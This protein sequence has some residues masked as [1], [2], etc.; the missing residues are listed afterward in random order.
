MANHL[1]PRQRKDFEIAVI[2]ALR[3]EVDAVEALFDVFWEE[4]ETYGKAVGDPNAYITGRLGDHNVVLVNLPGMGIASSSS[5]A[6]SLRSSFTGIKLGLVVGICGG[7]PF[8][9]DDEKEILLGDVIIS[10]GI[11]PFDTGRQFP[12][13]MVRKDTLQ[14]NLGRP[15]T[16]IRSCL[17]QMARRRGR[18]Q[19]KDRTA[20]YLKDLLE[21]EGFEGSKYPSTNEDIL[22][23]STYRH[24][25]QDKTACTICAKC[26]SKEDA[27]CVLALS[28]SCLELQCDQTKQV[29]RERLKKAKTV[30]ASGSAKEL[31]SAFTPAVHFGLIASG[32][33]V[34]KSGHHREDTAKK[35]KVI[36][37]EMEGSGAWDNFP[38][39]VIKGVCDYA[40]SP[41][42]KIWQQYAAATAAA[43]MKAFLNEWR[44]AD[45]PLQPRAEINEMGRMDTTSAHAISRKSPDV[46]QIKLKPDVVGNL[47]NA[48]VGKVV[49]TVV[50]LLCGQE[51][52]KNLLH[53]SDITG[54]RRVHPN[55]SGYS[56]V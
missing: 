20:E 32:G 14:E 25:H 36:A 10:T 47:Q 16:E 55:T 6:A 12:N 7:V 28:A 23:P 21:K 19:L 26:E 31:E 34:M 53:T 35:E 11:I 39:V 43:C 37:F 42:N 5:V 30:A 40:D 46:F 1:R 24:K 15:N 33:Q 44:V 56:H 22:Y 49:N 27:V 8:G 9:I 45:V 52:R 2:C 38:T 51:R 18:K 50:H 17:A 4:N 3:A 48:H 13:E 29:P 41:K 54:V